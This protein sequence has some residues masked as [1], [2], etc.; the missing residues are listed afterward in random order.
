MHLHYIQAM[1][2]ETI[3]TKSS[4]IPAVRVE[5]ALRAQM[6]AVLRE[7]ETLS[8]FVELVVREAVD[9]RLEDEAF[10]AKGLAAL[11]AMKAGGPS[12]SIDDVMASL[13]ARLDAALKARASIA[14][15]KKAA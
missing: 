9:R 12:R 14:K 13:Q 7:G 15:K 11:Q 5:P 8:G 6:E 10:V 1:P 4:T 2:S 3:P